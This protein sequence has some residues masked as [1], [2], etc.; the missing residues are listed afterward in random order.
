MRQ[1]KTFSSCSLT[2]KPTTDYERTADFLLANG[3]VKKFAILP[4]GE[5]YVRKMFMELGKIE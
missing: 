3:Y 1:A 4:Q 2:N 5:C